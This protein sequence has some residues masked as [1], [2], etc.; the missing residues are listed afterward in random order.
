MI[1]CSELIIFVSF[2][3][4]YIVAKDNFQTEILLHIII[5]DLVGLHSSFFAGPKWIFNYLIDFEVKC[6]KND[7]KL[8][9]YE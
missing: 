3:V 4:G 5:I 7:N 9:E 1:M 8:E 6:R 2:V